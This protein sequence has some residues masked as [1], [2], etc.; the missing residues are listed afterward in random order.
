ML[1]PLTHAL[2]FS[3]MLSLICRD[4]FLHSLKLSVVSFPLVL[5]GLLLAA[6]LV[7]PSLL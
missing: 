2:D 5:D 7:I 3:L 4:S 6:L 1:H